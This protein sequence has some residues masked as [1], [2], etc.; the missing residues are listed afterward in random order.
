MLIVKLPDGGRREFADGASAAD[1]AAAISPGL[2]RSGVC[3]EGDGKIADLSAPLRGA[4]SPAP[5]EV[6]LRILTKKDAEA[7][8]VMRH[9]AA[10]VMAQA[11]M[12]LFDGVGLAFGP[13]TAT[14]FYY[15]F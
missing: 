2:A 8:R 7:Y 5:N 11:V 12:R 13:T 1:V 6:S 15:D 10:H 14:G 9:S 4:Q 3:A